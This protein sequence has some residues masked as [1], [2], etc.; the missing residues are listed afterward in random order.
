MA[1]PS[2]ALKHGTFDVVGGVK[3][4]TSVACDTSIPQ[5]LVLTCFVAFIVYNVAFLFDID[6]PAIINFSTT[7]YRTIIKWIGII[8]QNDIRAIF[9]ATANSSGN[10]IKDTYRS[11]M[12]AH[13]F[14][15]GLKHMVSTRSEHLGRTILVDVVIVPDA[16]SLALIRGLPSNVSGP[17]L[18]RYLESILFIQYHNANYDVD[19]AP[20]QPDSDDP[21]ETPIDTSCPDL[22]NGTCVRP[23]KD[24][25]DTLSTSGIDTPS[26]DTSASSASAIEFDLEASTSGTESLALK[27]WTRSYGLQ[28]RSSSCRAD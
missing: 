11:N 21:E 8:R 12:Y 5:S 24:S 7:A 25:M 6:L 3:P 2:A 9:L 23:K 17:E 26:S 4:F 15:T 28:R 22:W 18:R 19:R 1:P 10:W 27:D 14:H 13:A 16:G 20:A